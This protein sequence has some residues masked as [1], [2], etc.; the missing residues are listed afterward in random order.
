MTAAAAS[1]HTRGHA[2]R[3]C[4]SG[5]LL[6]GRGDAQ[7][8]GQV[9][10]PMVSR[11]SEDADLVS[12]VP[13]GPCA[14]RQRHRH[15]RRL[16]R[17]RNCEAPSRRRTGWPITW[18]KRTAAASSACCCSGVKPAPTNVSD[19]QPSKQACEL[20][21]QTGGDV[22]W[23]DAKCRV[24]LVAV[25]DYAGFCRVIWSAHVQEMTDL[26]PRIKRIA[27]AWSWQS[28]VLCETCWRRTN[29]SLPRS[30]F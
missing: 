7:R 24:V 2:A 18:R 11:A 12:V 6:Q 10:V 4:D 17:G 15:R 25:P 20:C 8:R 26:P 23:R 19:H 30:A 5:A 9:C 16:H 1:R 21:A 29:S 13:A 3:H 28:S 14:Y 27:C 22:V